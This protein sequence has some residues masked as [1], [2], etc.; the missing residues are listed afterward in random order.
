MADELNYDD[1]DAELSQRAAES[2]ARKDD[3]GKFRGILRETE[4]VKMWRPGEG[5]HIFDIIPYRTGKHDP[6]LPAGALAYVLDVWVHFNVGATEDS[7]VCP[8]RTFSDKKNPLHTQERCPIC[9]QQ[10]ELRKSMERLED[11]DEIKAMEDQ[12]KALNPRRRV[13][14]NV[15]VLDN[16]AEEEKGV[17]IWDVAHWS[18]ERHLSVLSEKKRGPSGAVVGGH[19]PFASP[20][21]GKSVVF[22][23]KGKGMNTEFLGHRFEERQGYVIGPELLGAAKVLDEAI[24]IPT[25]NDLYLAYHGVAPGEEKPVAAAAAKPAEDI[26]ADKTEQPSTRRGLRTQVDDPKPAETVTGS[27]TKVE[28]S[29]ENACPAGGVYGRDADK[30]P[31]CR[32]CAD[33]IWQACSKLAEEAAA[34]APEG[35]GRRLRT[36]T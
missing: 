19:I 8:A 14:Y 33:P 4:G 27:E 24:N 32:K 12:I 22:S 35:E 2:F 15:L 28:G 10:N 25:Y 30:I 5:S 17:Q 16:A 29:K 1:F 31:G 6:K 36:T 7:F 20:K 34:A 21:T 23:K 26:T 18:M 3:T 11:D 13:L 9:E